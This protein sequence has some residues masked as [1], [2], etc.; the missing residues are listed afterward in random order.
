MAGTDDRAAEA[1]ATEPASARASE[2]AGTPT[3]RSTCG[4]RQG[5][6]APVR[7]RGAGHVAPPV[8][9]NFLL[10]FDTLLK[11]MQLDY[12][13]C[14]RFVASG[15]TAFM[16]RLYTMNPAMFQ[17]PVACD[18]RLTQMAL[19]YLSWFQD[20]AVQLVVGPRASWHVLP[21]VRLQRL[22][23]ELWVTEA[24]R[25]AQLPVGT[26]IA[27][28]DGRTLD[29]IRPEIERTLW[30]T[31]DPA[32]PEREDWSLVISFAR[33]VD[34][35]DD[36]APGGLQRVRLVMGDSTVVDRERARLSLERPDMLGTRA[37]ALPALELAVADGIATLTVR[38]P[39]DP[40][41]AVLAERA[42]EEL[43]ACGA[44][45]LVVD[46]RGAAGGSQQDAYPLV[47]LVLAPGAT[48]RPAELFGAPG[49]VLN[50][51]R[52]NVEARLAELAT[53]RVRLATDTDARG[54]AAG[55][56]TSRVADELRELDDLMR[57]LT[58]RKGAGLVHDDTD[59]Y[60]DVT[61]AAATAADGGPICG[62]RVVV[63]CD[64]GTA[65]AAEWLVRAAR[66]A[67]HSLVAGRA[68][69]GSLD[70]T[71]L[72]LVRLDDDFAI[73]VPTATYAGA[74]GKG[75]TLG[76]GIVPDE[77]LAWSPAQLVRDEELEAARRLTGMLASA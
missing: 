76:R 54:V 23:D 27:R 45:G 56:E 34:V 35:R 55:G 19:H 32:D 50:C 2:S 43:A 20:P 51:S 24:E 15:Y 18:R 52:H 64:R 31:V 49:I 66:S 77:H 58:E 28:V 33:D 40:T 47:P 39:G 72:R 37:A 3:G 26:R 8:Q 29:E 5:K 59:F 46:V 6:G 60:P 41:F 70:N 75:A 74:R 22:G 7:S 42:R 21:C 61:F 4:A 16:G 69:R 67:G 63:L 53:L 62:G 1:R 13:D 25:G 73:Q 44:R 48:A 14:A 17:S 11:V 9:R 68:T 38:R 57:E 30:T 71:S 65:D 10:D 12:V 36:E